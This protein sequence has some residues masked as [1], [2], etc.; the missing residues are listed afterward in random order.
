MLVG[1]LA[2]SHD[3]MEALRR[4]VDL[5]NRRRAA[6]VVHAGD[7]CSP[8]TR[9]VLGDLEGEFAGIFGNNDGDRLTLL[10]RYE[11]ALHRPPWVTS[12]G[13]RRAVLVHEPVLVDSLAAS[14]DFDLVVYGHT[15]RAAVR[16]KGGTLTVNP[17]KTARL[18]RGEATVALL[19]TEGMEVEIVPLF[20]KT[21]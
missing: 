15:H 5:F 8:F 18:H 16:R 3:D 1:M 12:L 19:D 6:I 17:G 9:E 2:D 10:E 7:F 4:A 13:G 20:G 11:G 21:G 14:G